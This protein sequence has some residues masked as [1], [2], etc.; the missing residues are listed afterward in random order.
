[1]IGQKEEVT[2]NKMT[3]NKNHVLSSQAGL[4]T[5]VLEDLNFPPLHY[6]KKWSNHFVGPFLQK[7]F[8]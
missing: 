5:G 3:T 1:M 2:I 6:E 7:T 4:H 8:K